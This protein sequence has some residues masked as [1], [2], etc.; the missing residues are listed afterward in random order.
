MK[1]FEQTTPPEMATWKHISINL[2]KEICKVALLIP[3]II[4]LAA[5][6]ATGQTTIQFAS[7]VGTPQAGI[8]LSGTGINPATGQVFRHLW[9]ADGANGLCRI[10][11]DVDT[12]V[13]HSI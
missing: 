10:D 8:I 3:V 7:G 1:C 13:A 6:A 2:I 9:S 5:S 4:A 12:Q 11:A